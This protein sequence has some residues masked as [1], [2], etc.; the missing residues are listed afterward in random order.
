MIAPDGPVYQAGTLAGNPIVTAAGLVTLRYLARHPDL[1]LRFEEAGERIASRLGE[2]LAR[3]GLP[4]VVTHAGGMV[5]L[6]LGIDRATSWDDVAGLDQVLFNRFFQAALARGILLPPSPFETWFLME[7]HLDST[8][9][10]ALNGLCEAI[11]EAMDES[12]R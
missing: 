4:G 1:Y 7:S 5:G 2:A 12:G 6:F 9:D 3:A 10:I 11:D 8:L